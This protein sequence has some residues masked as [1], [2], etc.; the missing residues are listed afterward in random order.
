MG[1]NP[2]GFRF[3][4][5][6]NPA[7]KISWDAIQELYDSYGLPPSI[8]VRYLGDGDHSFKPRVKSGRTLEQNIDEAVKTAA[9]FVAT[10]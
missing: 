8:R 4:G 10:L 3:P 7:D 9:E 6:D 5:D 2:G 1:Q